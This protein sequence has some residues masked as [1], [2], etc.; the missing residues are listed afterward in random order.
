MN[1]TCYFCLRDIEIKYDKKNHTISR[2][3]YLIDIK[4]SKMTTTK[5]H[6]PLKDVLKELVNYVNNK[7]IEN[8]DDVE[9]S[10]MLEM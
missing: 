3:E 5:F 2:D 4:L 9:F 1:C 6:D 8:C 10:T 7:I